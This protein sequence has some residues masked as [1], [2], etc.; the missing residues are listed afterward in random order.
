[1]VIQ[2]TLKN[3]YVEK[4]FFI[5]FAFLPIS[6]VAGPAISLS[7]IILI[8]ISFIILI[9]FL[10]EYK[11]FFKIEVKVI[12][13]IFLYLIFNNLIS[14]DSNIATSRSFGFIRFLIFFIATN[15]F[16]YKYKNFSKV[17]LFW[18]FIVIFI[19]SDV[20]FESYTGKNYLGYGQGDRIFSFFVD[21]P[22]VGGF[23]NSFYL[24]LVGY[25]FLNEGSNFFCKKHIILFLTFVFLISIIIT[26]ERSNAI[27]AILGL[28]IFLLYLNNYILKYKVSFLFITIFVFS[29]IFSQSEFLKLRYQ[30]QLLDKFSTKEK[31]EFILKNNPY[32]KLQ[33]SGLEVFKDNI[34]FGVGN[35]NYR[36][37]TC[38]PKTK[39]IAYYYCGTHPHQTIIEILSEHGIVGTILLLSL[40]FILF[41]K[42]FKRM[43]ISRNQVQLGCFIYIFITFLPLLPS[44]AFFG[45]SIMT[46][47]WINASVLYAVS[48]HTNIFEN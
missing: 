28:S 27:K 35:K 17:L 46:S 31:R 48:R 2:N 8:D 7:N 43:I 1:M 22:V 3:N 15:Y 26:G 10:R 25:L 24:M 20:F 5:L 19:V 37:T 34:L 41:V 4:Y 39:I 21:E 14:L 11:F 30:N 45:D 13:A 16:F 42:A 29:I 32:L 6:I 12:F 9:I 40:F 38:D 18:F 44:G 33:K 47:F 36:V 23:I